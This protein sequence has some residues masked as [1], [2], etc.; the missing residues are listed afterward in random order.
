MIDGMTVQRLAVKYIDKPWGRDILPPLFADVEGR[1]IGEIWFDGP[2]G[3]TPP[4]LVKYIF[5]GERLSIQVHPD[6]AQARARGLPGGKTECWYIV[7]AEPDARIGIGTLEA[8]SPDALRAAALDGG[9]ERLM[10]WKP[11]AAGDFWYI[12]AGTVHA[13]GGG[14]SLVE[15][16]QNVDITYRLYDYGRPR[17]LHLDDGVAVAV[18]KPYDAPPLKL[19]GVADKVLVDG[20]DAPFVVALRSFAAGD[21]RILGGERPHWFVPLAGAGTIDG[22]PWAA[23]ECWLLDRTAAFMCSADARALVATLD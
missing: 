17:D 19:T 16:Q 7:D 22:Q 2:P 3:R 12:P 1:R 21:R 20:P 4:L 8:L 18:A 5:T 15:V 14:V 11:V 6:D 9:I 10:D 13:I 23:G